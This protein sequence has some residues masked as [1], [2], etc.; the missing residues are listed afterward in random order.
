[1]L[2]GRLCNARHRRS[3]LLRFNNM[4]WRESKE[5]IEEFAI[6]V[7]ASALALPAQVSDDAMLD[8]FIQTLP[9][10]IKNPAL[11]IPGSFDE[12][13]A[14]V[15]MMTGPRRRDA[16]PSRNTGERVN[17]TCDGKDIPGHEQTALVRDEDRRT[18]DEDRFAN[19]ICY[20]CGK[21]GHMA[22][23]CP[24]KGKKLQSSKMD[25]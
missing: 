3:L 6:C 10:G 14:R 23:A 16:F 20:R 1:M 18:H 9:S 8:R 15:S 11:A 2:E 4:S 13:T 17:E 12:V 5:C 19:V 24:T 21:K 25:G 22:G 7:R